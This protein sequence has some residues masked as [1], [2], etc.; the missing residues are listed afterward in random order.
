MTFTEHSLKVSLFSSY[1]C[2]WS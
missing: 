1:K 2:T